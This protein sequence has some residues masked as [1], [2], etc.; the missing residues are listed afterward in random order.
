MPV[1]DEGIGGYVILWKNRWN[2]FRVKYE[3]YFLVK[4]V[5]LNSSWDL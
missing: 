2:D 3:G 4:G 5:V 1:Y